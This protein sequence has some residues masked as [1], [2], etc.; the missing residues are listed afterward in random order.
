MTSKKTIV[1]RYYIHENN[2]EYFIFWCIC[3]AEY[4]GHMQTY[5]ASLQLGWWGYDMKVLFFR[6]TI[7]YW[8]G[9]KNMK[10]GLERIRLKF[11]H[12]SAN[13]TAKFAKYEIAIWF[14]P[15]IK[16]GLER[17]GGRN[18]LSGNIPGLDRRRLCLDKC[19]V[20]RGEQSP[21]LS[22]Q[23]IKWQFGKYL[24]QLYD[25]ILH[26]TALQSIYKKENPD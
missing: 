5:I 14:K 17:T 7:C 9:G 26:Q 22:R 13:Q 18:Q 15:V 16:I 24:R 12:T 19:E 3:T 10:F 1:R 11:A 6:P 8:H 21:D 25:C 2:K 23:I 20:M 4:R